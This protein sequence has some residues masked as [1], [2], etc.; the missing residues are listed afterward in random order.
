M[1]QEF[2]DRLQALLKEKAFGG[3][4]DGYVYGRLNQEFTL[5]PEELNKMASALG[6]KY[7][8]NPSVED[9]LEEQW[10]KDESRWM[11]EKLAKAQRQL[12]HHQ[13]KTD[14]A[15]KID[16]TRKKAALYQEIE[17]SGRSNREMTDIERAL[18]GLILKMEASD[19]LWLLETIFNRLRL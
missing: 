1:R 5:Y 19:Q 9:I 18:V 17:A 8:W 10:Q 2:L 4:R 12:S 13:Q 6:F 7:G 15:S 14:L 3:W 16:E 11:Q